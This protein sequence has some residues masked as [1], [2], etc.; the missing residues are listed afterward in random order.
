MNEVKLTII[1]PCYNEGAA[2]PSFISKLSEAAK[3]IKELVEI[4]L[5][6]DGSSDNTPEILKDIPQGFNSI[7]HPR[8]RGYGAALKTG[9]K[10]AK[11]EWI[12]IIDAD[13]TYGPEELSN[14]WDETKNNDMVV[15]RRTRNIG[16]LRSIPKW[17]LTRLATILSGA[18]IP[19]LNSGLRIFRKDIARKFINLYPDGFSFT[20]TI[21]LAFLCEGYSVHFEPI[22]YHKRTG[23]SK[24]H[25]IKDTYNFFTLI[26]KIILYF[27]PLKV[28]LPISLGLI[29]LG[30]VVLF[31][32]WHLGQVMDVTVTVIYMLAIHVAVLGLLADLMIKRSRPN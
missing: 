17:I 19:D 7:S 20:T 32:T 27:N 24:I 12:A 28:L 11:G 29:A 8:N 18:P 15:G 1:V 10:N 5:V 2:L 31:W 13:G 14:L 26:L 4:I 16:F 9:L 3:S 30:T 21:T 25:P 22:D 23:H 6:D